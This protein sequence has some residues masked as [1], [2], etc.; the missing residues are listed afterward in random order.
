MVLPNLEL[1]SLGMV[2]LCIGS[3]LW[4]KEKYEK[5]L[6]RCKYCGSK[7]LRVKSG[8]IICK[9]GHRVRLEDH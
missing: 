2:G 9:N 3:V 8:V 6:V 7:E 4:R 5:S 1:F